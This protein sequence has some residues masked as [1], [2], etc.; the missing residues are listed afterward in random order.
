MQARST[1]IIGVSIDEER[2]MLTGVLLEENDRGLRL[3]RC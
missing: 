2:P 3:V 1:A